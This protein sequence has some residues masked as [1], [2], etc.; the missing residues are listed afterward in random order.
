MRCSQ[1]LPWILQ[2]TLYLVAL[3]TAPHTFPDLSQKISSRQ[4]SGSVPPHSASAFIYA[5]LSRPENLWTWWQSNSFKKCRSG[6]CIDLYPHI[7]PASKNMQVMFDSPSLSLQIAPIDSHQIATIWP[8]WW[9]TLGKGKGMSSVLLTAGC[10]LFVY[11]LLFLLPSFSQIC[12]LS[13][14]S[15]LIDWS[16]PMLLRKEKF[17][18]SWF[19]THISWRPYSSL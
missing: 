14:H 17:W 7:F 10:W 8:A 5:N 11:F 1:Q 18:S 9:W 6:A 12:F 13:I 16:P 4:S 2:L 19:E 3:L 15:V